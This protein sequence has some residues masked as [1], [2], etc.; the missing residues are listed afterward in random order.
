M[1]GL[2]LHGESADIIARVRACPVGDIK[3]HVMEMI[4]Q[5][6]QFRAAEAHQSL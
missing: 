1:F 2:F 5:L 6:V 4:S 3:G